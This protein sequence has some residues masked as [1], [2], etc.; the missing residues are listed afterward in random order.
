MKILNVLGFLFT[1]AIFTIIL[2]FI[3]NIK[4]SISILY[5]FLI[6]LFILCLGGL[7][8]RWLK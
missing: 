5:V 6:T 7:I 2:Y 3:I 8:K 1:Y 4:S